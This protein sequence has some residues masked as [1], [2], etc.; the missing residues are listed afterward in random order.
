MN[1]V[2]TESHW[3]RFVRLTLAILC[4]ATAALAA[5]DVD[6]DIVYVRQ[7]R[8]GDNAHVKWP[9]V[10]HPALIEPGCDLML[11]HPDGSEEV[12]VDAG[13]GAC[14]DPFVSFDGKWVF[15]AFF[16]QVNPVGSYNISKAGSDIYK[17]NLETREKVRLTHQEFTPNMGAGTWIVDSFID[18]PVWI[19]NS[20]VHGIINL[21]P[22]PISGGK[23]AFVSSRNGFTP[24]KLYY[25]APTLQLFVMD[26]DGSNV[27]CIAPMNI[28]SA[29][30]PV[31]L[32]DGR[33][34]F[35]SY[36]SQGVRDLR[37]WGLW[38]IWPDGR[39]W[40]PLM[41]SFLSGQA[42]HFT[43]QLSNEDIVVEN[44]YN[45]NNFGFGTLYS[46][47]PTPPQG[48]APFQSWV[49]K[50]NTWLKQVLANGTQWGQQMGFTP[51]G[52][53]VLTPFSS[54]ADEAAAVGS[55]GNRVGKFTH[56]CAA[57]NNDLLVAYSSGPV[58]ALNRPTQWPAADAGIYLIPG[59]GVVN[60]PNELVKL[61]NSKDWNEVWPRPV[62]SYEDVHGVAEPHEFPFLPNDG[63]E[64]E[65]LPEGTPYGLVGTSSMIK[66]DTFPGYVVS[67]DNEFDG[68]D[69][70]NTTENEQSSNWFVQGADA[71]KYKDSDIFAV[72]ILAMEPVT[73]RY[74][75]PNFGRHYESHAGERLRILGEIPVRKSNPDGSPVM[76][77]EGNPDTSFLAK[78]PADTPFTFQTL[79]KNGLVLNMAQ[80][81][82]QVR[83]GEV[84]ND[85]GGCHAHSQ[86]PLAF[87]LTAA[88]KPEYEIWDLSKSTPKTPLLAKNE[89]GET[90]VEYLNENVEDV[91]FVKDI[92]PILKKHCAPCHTK[93]DPTPPGNLV[94]DDKK[95]KGSLPNDYRRI[96]WDKEADWGYKPLV[97]VG[98]DPEWR[99]T[100]ASRYV[101]QFQ[102]RRSLLTWKVFGKRLDG[103][104]N[105]D[106]P[107]E[108][109]PGDPGS[110]KANVN[111]ND[112]DLDYTGSIMPPPDS[113]V[114]PLTEK[115]KMTIA[116]WIDLGCPI[117]LAKKENKGF[118]WYLD[119]LRP[120]LYVNSPRPGENQGPI[121][122]FRVGFAD[123]NSGIKPNSLF[124]TLSIPMN[125]V[126]S[127]G[128][129]G[130][131]FVQVND[132][133][134]EM[135]LNEALPP[136]TELVL[137]AKVSDREGNITEHDVTFY[138]TE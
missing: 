91:E 131:Q 79:D 105:K 133:V 36:E 22:C 66:R 113:G 106:H 23:V 83:P 2:P 87:N 81:W 57:P 99:Q 65:A 97:T 41:S 110:L 138:V 104:T 71:G 112:C 136:S 102:S 127:G 8:A 17:I 125:G 11:L 92:R 70:F 54:G 100:N 14:T 62:V 94:L 72:R 120:T 118:G 42:L 16:H 33:I 10:F 135:T 68:L 96:A 115:Q 132:G 80:T 78:I 7:P 37:Q 27:E 15:Y 119:D 39:K 101:R 59:G 4:I 56:P 85:C 123:A 77:P 31:Q 137:N 61:K 111:P 84:R 64:H 30:H 20:L 117:D 35:S 47:P 67:Y 53:E 134:Y 82:H 60:G 73:D 48:E 52:I 114:P 95:M 108:K 1:V 19:A 126:S 5:Q 93:K 26:E 50:D 63:T 76:D 124:V 88:G 75:G 55:N 3:M 122:K 69:A 128:N 130:N 103:W 74:R 13:D 32:K 107:T 44:Y 12:L 116:R 45:L 46:I 58:N 18:N 51:K 86:M 43:T 21:G 25:T 34:M 24:P 49:R 6:Y 129:L 28:G 98:G 109:I 38:A 29:L 121:T 89:A 40:E 90:I 9:E